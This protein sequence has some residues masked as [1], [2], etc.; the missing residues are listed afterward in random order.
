MATTTVPATLSANMSGIRRIGFSGTV[1]TEPAGMP[2]ANS[3]P[4][5]LSQAMQHRHSASSLARAQVIQCQGTVSSLDLTQRLQRPV[6]ATGLDQTQRPVTANGLDRTQHAE[7]ALQPNAVLGL[8]RESTPNPRDQ[9]AILLKRMQQS[10]SVTLPPN[11]APNL[12][13]QL[14]FN[15]RVRNLNFPN[16][17][18]QLDTHLN[19]TSNL[20]NSA[21]QLRQLDG[22]PP[23]QMLSAVPPTL[24]YA[25]PFVAPGVSPARQH[26]HSNSTVREH[27][28]FDWGFK[29]ELAKKD[30]EN[31]VPMK[32][33]TIFLGEPL[34]DDLLH[35]SPKIP[36]HRVRETRKYMRDL[37][38]YMHTT[39]KVPHTQRIEVNMKNEVIGGN[40]RILAA[41]L[42]RWDSV[43]ALRVD[44]VAGWHVP[45]EEENRQSLENVLELLD[46]LYSL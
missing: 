34:I 39:W 27:S 6:I 14:T 26:Y 5:L 1:P 20:P 33:S 40:H 21:R 15:H 24:V 36:E 28:Q 4:D 7:T 9:S 10:Q 2:R 46:F 42:L 25:P 29:A 30:M 43:C 8:S 37:V 44:K 38:E 35:P 16:L 12:Q 41:W 11:S 13:R 32:L 18:K 31:A 19:A 45:L 23:A 22:H 17:Q 3:L